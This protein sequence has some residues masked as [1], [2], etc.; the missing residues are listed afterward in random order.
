[1]TR[2]EAQNILQLC[3]PDHI[4][5][6]NDPLIAE[7]LEQMEQDSEL[8]TWFEEQQLFDAKIYAELNRIEPPEDLKATILKGMQDPSLQLEKEASLREPV[9]SNTTDTNNI[10]RIAWFRPWMGIAAVFLLLAVFL[11]L[12]R[13]T[14]TQQLAG[15][16][17]TEDT[18]AA[19]AG[20]PDIIQFLEQQ[21]GNFNGSKFDQRSEAVD[22][23]Q[24]FLAVS[25]MPSPV[26][27]PPKLEALPTLGCVTFDY[28]GAQLSMICFKN[29]KVYHLI[30]INK[31][32]L[33]SDRLSE[34]GLPGVTFFEHRQ[35]AFKLWSRGDQIYIL[36]IEGTKEEIPEFI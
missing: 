28:E 32:D 21:I 14:Q 11:A 30:T 27:V 4:E 23:L 19:V 13:K 36:S 33:T 16:Q 6:L 7:A 34:C 17:P 22:E 3:R 20:I 35:Q 18:T 5:D 24:S 10:T 12:P 8:C 1:M 9:S 25:G 15:K 31:A 26:A 2:E 29:D